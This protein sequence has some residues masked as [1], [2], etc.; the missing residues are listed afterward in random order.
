M[1]EFQIYQKNLNQKDKHK[2]KMSCHIIK[3]EDYKDFVGF[4]EKEIWGDF[5][6]F[7]YENWLKEQ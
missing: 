4:S 5:C 3:E 2:I 1:N 7:D 6:D